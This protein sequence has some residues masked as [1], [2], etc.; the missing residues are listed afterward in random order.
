MWRLKMKTSPLLSRACI[1]KYLPPFVLLMGLEIKLHL[2]D[3]LVCVP[4]FPVVL[5]WHLQCPALPPPHPVAQQVARPGSGIGQPMAPQ[6]LVRDR[7]EARFQGAFLLIAPSNKCLLP[8]YLSLSVSF[9]T[10]ASIN[11][12]LLIRN[13]SFSTFTKKCMSLLAWFSPRVVKG[14]LVFMKKEEKGRRRNQGE[15]QFRSDA[16]LWA[17]VLT[18][19]KDDFAPQATLGNDWRYFW[20][21]Q[22]RRYYWHLVNRGQRCC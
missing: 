11:T 21:P 5:K 20:L 18:A 16:A 9:F 8:I 6:M 1:W 14:I 3:F 7:R 17:R 13:N 15:V 12:W 10:R 19:L 2:C 22:L 4:T